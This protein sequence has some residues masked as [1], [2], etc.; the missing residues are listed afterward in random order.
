[1][2]ILQRPKYAFYDGDVRP[3]S[4]ATLHVS[5][6]G[7]YRGLNVFEGLKGYWQPDGRMGIVAN[8]AHFDRLQRSAKILHIPFEHS[9]EAFDDAC[10]KLLQILSMPEMDSWI[11]A[12]VYLTEGLWGEDQKSDLVLTAFHTPKALPDPI[13]I[14]ISTWRRAADTMLPARVKTGANYMVAR[15][16]RIDGRPRG[17]SEMI[18]LNNYDRVAEAGGACILMVRGGKVFTPPASEGTLESITVDIV[19]AL[20]AELKIPFERRPIE[21]TEL[22]IADEMSLAGTLAELTPVESVDDRPLISRLD[23]LRKLA[24]RYHAAVT[25][26]DPH[27]S[28]DLSLRRYAELGIAEVTSA[29]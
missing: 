6:E 11:R 10:H 3:W 8:R 24:L 15:L 9:Y 16:A 12:T 19:E 22:Y 20:A 18:Q 27:P 1:M 17:W 7:V 2:V 26:R 25:G 14:G 23:L 21:R 4:G 13:R 29:S 28:T 5:S